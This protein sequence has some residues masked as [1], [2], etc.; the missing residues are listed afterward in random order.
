MRAGHASST[1]RATS[2]GAIS[3]RTAERTG[4]GLE[5]SGALGAS[6]DIVPD[7]LAATLAVSG[8][9][10]TNQSGDVFNTTQG[11]DQSGAQIAI[12]GLP[13]FAS[14]LSALAG[15]GLVL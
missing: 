12:G 11:F 4:V 15:I 3:I 2:T 10:V 5:F 6:V 8:A 14:S 13:R 1:G 7:W 9:F